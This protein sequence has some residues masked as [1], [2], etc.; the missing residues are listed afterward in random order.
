MSSDGRVTR[1]IHEPFPVKTGGSGGE[2]EK[3]G[4]GKKS[5]LGKRSSRNKEGFRTPS[6]KKK[7]GMGGKKKISVL[8]AS[9]WEAE[10]ESA[11]KEPIRKTHG[12][13]EQCKNYTHFSNW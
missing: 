7:R 2:R 5:P 10:K 13:P 12:L 1:S 11:A 6:I 9:N 3:K 4:G 8:N